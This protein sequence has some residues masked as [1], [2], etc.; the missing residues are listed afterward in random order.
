M[1]GNSWRIW[2]PCREQ[3]VTDSLCDK[4]ATNQWNT[5]RKMSI[6]IMKRLSR[7]VW[8]QCKNTDKANVLTWPPAR[9]DVSVAYVASSSEEEKIKLALNMIQLWLSDK[10]LALVA[11]AF[12]AD[13]GR[14][15]IDKTKM[16]LLAQ[17]LVFVCSSYAMIIYM[18]YT[19][20]IHYKGFCEGN[21]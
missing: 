6:W 7:S 13:Q 2:T 11:I 15:H 3:R 5:V 10:T 4:L 20:H 21:K 17:K 1:L 19:L 8:E 14:V 16:K 12:S 9:S 18:H